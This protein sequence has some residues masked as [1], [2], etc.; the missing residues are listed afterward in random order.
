MKTAVVISD[1]HGNMRLL[2]QLY[3]IFSECDY[4]IHLGDTSADGAKIM[5]DFPGKVI[6][7]NGNCDLV[8]LGEDEK[9]L[10]LEG[11]K[12]FL[13]HG[14]LYSAKTTQ[15]RLAERAKELGCTLAFYGHT[16]AAR[17]ETVDGVTL[18]NPGNT[19][20]YSQNGYCYLAVHTGKATTKLVTL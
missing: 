1:S 2:T 5:R 12:I 6:L 17:E 11:V 16:H 19:S 14:H 3:P 4:I 15:T 13:T 9:V 7:V 10:E 8:K 20:R 18:V